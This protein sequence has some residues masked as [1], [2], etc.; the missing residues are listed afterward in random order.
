MAACETV[1]LAPAPKVSVARSV[2]PVA[3]VMPWRVQKSAPSN[4]PRS[5]FPKAP[6]H[7]AI[8]INGG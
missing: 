2:S 3:G 6:S 5:A 7:L 4:E 8:P 1:W